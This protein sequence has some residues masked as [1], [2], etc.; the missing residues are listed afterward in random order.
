MNQPFLNGSEQLRKAEI[1]KIQ[2]IGSAVPFF[3]KSK[4]RFNTRFWSSNY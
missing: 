2:A 3:C 4:R 1:K